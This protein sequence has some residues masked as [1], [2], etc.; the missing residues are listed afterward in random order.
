MRALP[1]EV[2]RARVQAE[3]I[4]G[5][6]EP[7]SGGVA[8][9]LLSQELSNPRGRA[10]AAVGKDVQ[11]DSGLAAIA[12]G[13]RLWLCKSLEDPDCWRDVLAGEAWPEDVGCGRADEKDA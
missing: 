4:S 2:A 6:D 9:E 7:V 12:G 11:Q 8:A 13:R 3:S 1:H 10:D 5:D